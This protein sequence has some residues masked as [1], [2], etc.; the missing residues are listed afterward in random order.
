MTKKIIV[1]FFLIV[2]CV[3][4]VFG[5]INK[6]ENQTADDLEVVF[7]YIKIN[8]NPTDMCD[9]VVKHVS[10]NSTIDF[11]AMTAN[12]MIKRFYVSSKDGQQCDKELTFPPKETLKCIISKDQKG[13]LSIGLSD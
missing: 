2:H 4:T 12:C 8:A 10:A 3:A 6:L 13:K 1:G 5:S 9:M 7:K 11:E